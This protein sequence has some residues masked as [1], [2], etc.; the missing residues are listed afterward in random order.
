MA[1]KRERLELIFD[2]LKSVRD[3]GNSIK[4]TRLLHSSN[5][6]PQMFKEYIDELLSKGFIELKDSVGKKEYS[7]TNK[8]FEFLQKYKVLVEFIENFG[9]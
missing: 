8:G 7:L 1:K 4:P 5:L 6:S 9:L 2:I 3:N